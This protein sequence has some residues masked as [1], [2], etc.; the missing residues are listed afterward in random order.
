MNNLIRFGIS[1]DENLLKKFDNIIN[2]KG[3]VNRSEAIR[4]LI[5][6]MMDT[7][8]I[9]DPDVNAVGTLSLVYNHDIRDLAD[10]LNEI[11]HKYYKNIKSTTHIHLDEHNCLEI[12]VLMGKA[13]II[14]EISDRLIAIKNV[15]HGKLSITPVETK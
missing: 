12:L 5:R 15:K 13:R 11:Q 14:N 10:K 8:E 9:S 7:D 3:Y 6:N 4:D 2:K 1:M